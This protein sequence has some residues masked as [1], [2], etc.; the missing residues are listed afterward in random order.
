VDKKGKAKDAPAPV[1]TWE[2]RESSVDDAALRV[3]LEHGY[4]LFKVLVHVPSA[5]T[6]ELTLVA[7]SS[8]TAHSHLSSATSASRR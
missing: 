1:E 7:R 8:R 4:E 2:Y 3:H 6:R 5:Q